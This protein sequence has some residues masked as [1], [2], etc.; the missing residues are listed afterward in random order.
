MIWRAAESPRWSGGDF[1]RASGG[2]VERRAQPRYGSRRSSYKTDGGR[3]QLH[4]L[5][6]EAS[7]IGDLRSVRVVVMRRGLAVG[8]I[9]IVR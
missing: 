3:R 8:A 5:A 4:R 7:Q 1:E 6:V 9:M 2:A